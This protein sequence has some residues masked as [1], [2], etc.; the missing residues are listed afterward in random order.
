MIL[1]AFLLKE[2]LD[3]FTS[4]VHHMSDFINFKE[5]K[6]LYAAQI[7]RMDQLFK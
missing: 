5:L 3:V 2:V 6:V 4:A 7:E 1:Y